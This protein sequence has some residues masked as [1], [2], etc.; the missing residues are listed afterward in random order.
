MAYPLVLLSA[1]I[2]AMQQA[3][4]ALKSGSTASAPAQVNFEELKSIVGFPEYYDRETRYQA[5]E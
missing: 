5:A 4:G 3:L 2:A 1:A